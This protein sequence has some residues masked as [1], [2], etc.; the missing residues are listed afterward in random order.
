MY[1][2]SGPT[3]SGKKGAFADNGTYTVLLYCLDMWRKIQTHG[4]FRIGARCCFFLCSPQLSSVSKALASFCSSSAPPTPLLVFELQ[5][6]L[7]QGSPASATFCLA[8]PS[9][10]PQI[11]S[12]FALSAALSSVALAL[13][14]LLVAPT[15]FANSYGNERRFEGVDPVSPQN[16]FITTQQTQILPGKR[17]Q[18]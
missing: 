5:Y 8:Q 16:D 12:S 7:F 10:S 1:S 15:P 9:G 6:P 11:R 17:H 14:R 3:E 18:T 4:I 13:R 2:Q